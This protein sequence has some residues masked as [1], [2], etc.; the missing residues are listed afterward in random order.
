MY[1]QTAQMTCFP[2]GSLV[3][4]SRQGKSHAQERRVLPRVYS[5]LR[6]RPC[7]AVEAMRERPLLATDLGRL[8]GPAQK[9]T[10]G[11]DSS[12]WPCIVYRYRLPR[13]RVQVTWAPLQCSR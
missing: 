1:K 2:K 8:I 6:S 9:D 7:P 13:E 3:P 5:S 10:S 4:V 11:P 12:L